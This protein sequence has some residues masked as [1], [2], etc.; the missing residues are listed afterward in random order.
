MSLWAIFT[1][2]PEYV[3]MDFSKGLSEAIQLNL[4]GW[5]HL[6]A[7]DYE[8]VPF[9]CNFCHEYGHF[10]KSCPKLKKLG[11]CRIMWTRD[12]NKFQ[13]SIRSSS[14]GGLNLIIGLKLAHLFPPIID[15]KLWNLMM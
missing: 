14:P 7:L 5:S 1:H 8:Q 15:L 4:D 6:Q 3:Y 12:S 11:H 13:E 10:I 9:K 2:V